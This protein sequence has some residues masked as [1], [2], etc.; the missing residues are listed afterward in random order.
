M[1]FQKVEQTGQRGHGLRLR[2]HAAR[3][4]P[5]RHPSAAGGAGRGAR[6]S[7]RRHRLDHR[8]RAR[9]ARRGVPPGR[10]RRAARA[11]R[12]RPA[13]AHPAAGLG[14]ALRGPGRRQ[15]PPPRLPV[16]RPHGRRRLRGRRH[17]V[18][19]GRP[20]TAATRSTRPRS[21]TGAGAPTA[22]RRGHRGITEPSTEPAIRPRPR[23]RTDVT[24]HGSESE[25]PVIPAPTPS[26]TR[27]QDEPGLVA[28]P[29]RPAGPPP[30]LAAVQPDGRGLRLRRG[31]QDP[32]RRGA[33]AGPLRGDDDVAGLVAGRLRPLRAALHP[34]ELA[35]RRHVPHRRRPRRRRR[36]AR[37]A[38]PR[39]TAGP[40]TRA[41]TRR[42]GC[43]GRS[44]RSTA[45]RSPGPT[46]WSSPATAPWSRW[47]SRRS[48]SASG[49]RTSGSPRRSSGAPRTRGSATS[50]TAATG[51]SPVRSAPCRWA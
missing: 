51:S 39:S 6:A 2:A 50:A 27:P 9:R 38:S 31:V 47:A 42:A 24:D 23:R 18:P 25:N 11:D 10:V 21:S 30:A 43:S 14:G 12:R 29:A 46:C 13:A 26:A 48:A 36:A 45:G 22:S 44:S 34:D 7:A 28:E 5:P 4:E 20:T 19:D 49:A 37:S 17:A 16:V 33:E 1:Q 3:G 8:R 15:P 35:R 40:T 41:S 32:R